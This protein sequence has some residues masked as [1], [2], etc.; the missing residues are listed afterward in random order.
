MVGRA[1]HPHRYYAKY[2][3]CAQSVNIIASH[4]RN[5]YRSAHIAAQTYRAARRR[6][7]KYVL[8]SS[9]YT[10]L[11][12]FKKWMRTSYK[13]LTLYVYIYESRQIFFC[14][15]HEHP[16]EQRTLQ[17]WETI[18]GLCKAGPKTKLVNIFHQSNLLSQHDETMFASRL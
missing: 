10:L 3:R 17:R 16:A 5:P 11:L 4:C 14:S 15:L 7:P 1:P 6:R 12:S 13:Y 9:T 8:L 2:C 18:N